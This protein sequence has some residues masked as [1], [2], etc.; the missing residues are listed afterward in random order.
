MRYPVAFNNVFSNFVD[1]INIVWDSTHYCTP[2]HLTTEEAAYFG[3]F[4]MTEVTPPT[5]DPVTQS[6][7]EI[8]PTFGSDVW[9]QQWQVN[10]LSAD[11]ITANRLA[12]VPTSITMRQAR[13]A[14]LGAGLLDT[15]NNAISAM[16]GAAGQEAQIIWQYSNTV[17]LDN[18]L[19]TSLA[20]SLNLTSD[21][22][23]SLFTTA[24][25]L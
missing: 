10:A 13:L 3:V 1:N 11:Q 25:T 14:L 5:F 24:N 22:I 17:E 23:N 21:Q 2:D 16:T 15:V 19:I 8:T 7:T 20:S 4:L 12:L 9:T 6:L 18:P